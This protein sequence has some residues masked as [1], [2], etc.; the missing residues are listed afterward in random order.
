MQIENKNFFFKG[1]NIDIFVSPFI[2]Q[3]VNFNIEKCLER[4][5]DNAIHI[6]TCLYIEISH[7]LSVVNH[8]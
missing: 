4:L 5:C 8:V 2:N 3:N 6:T 1:I 7:Y